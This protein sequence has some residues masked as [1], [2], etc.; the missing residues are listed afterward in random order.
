MEDKLL[1]Q[2]TRGVKQ[3]VLEDRQNQALGHVPPNLR[4]TRQEFHSWTTHSVTPRQHAD[5]EDTYHAQSEVV[6]EIV[7]TLG[8]DLLVR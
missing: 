7:V 2:V 1:D 4:R 3:D 5:G 6:E 8:R